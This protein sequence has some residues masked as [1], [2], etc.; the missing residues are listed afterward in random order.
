MIKL[1]GGHCNCLLGAFAQAGSC[2]S[3]FLGLVPAVVFSIGVVAGSWSLGNKIWQ[4]S[5]PK[6]RKTNANMQK[7]REG[8]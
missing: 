8:S 1:T 3:K 6:T 7:G 2:G 5:P 4:L